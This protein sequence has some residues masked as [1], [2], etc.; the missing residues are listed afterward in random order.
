MTRPKSQSSS[1]WVIG[2]RGGAGAGVL[3][4]EF[5]TPLSRRSDSSQVIGKLTEALIRHMT[6]TLLLRHMTARWLKGSV[7]FV[8]CALWVFFS[9]PFPSFNGLSGRTCLSQSEHKSGP[10]T[11]SN[12]SDV[13]GCTQKT[14]GLKVDVLETARVIWLGKRFKKKK[15]KSCNAEDGRRAGG[16]AGGGSET[17][18]LIGP[19]WIL[20]SGSTFSPSLSINTQQIFIQPTNQTDGRDQSPPSPIRKRW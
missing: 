20:V 9:P 14:N 8:S 2:G 15:K 3:W 5:C 13:I 12:R 7:A 10:V 16:G 1:T 4:S 17:C 19:E 6:S 11:F 18:A